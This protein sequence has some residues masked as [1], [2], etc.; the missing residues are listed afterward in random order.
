MTNRVEDN[1]E[2]LHVSNCIITGEDVAE[3]LGSEIPNF[4][5]LGLN[6]SEIYRVYRPKAELEKAY[7]TL[8][9]VP[10]FGKHVWGIPEALRQDLIIGT[11][12]GDAAMSNAQILNTVVFWQAEAKDD[13]D[14]GKKY[15]SAG[16]DYTPVVEDGDWNGNKY[17]VRMTN[18]SFNHV[19]LVDNP[20][21]KQAG[22]A[23]SADNLIKQKQGVIFMKLQ[24]FLKK[25]NVGAMDSASRLVL[26]KKSLDKKS[27]AKF[28]RIA[29]A[30]DEE[31]QDEDP[32]AEDEDDEAQKANDESGAEDDG[33][34]DDE[35]V[36]E[37]EE[38]D[39]AEDEAKDEDDGAKDEEEPAPKGMDSATQLYIQKQINQGISKGIAS[40]KNSI[41]HE[42]GAMD[43]AVNLCTKLVGNVNRG[44]FDSADALYSNVLKQKGVSYLGKTTAQKMAKVEALVETNSLKIKQSGA[45]DKA[46]DSSGLSP[47]YKRLLGVN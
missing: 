12:G 44:A 6:P 4:K 45:M 3:Y 39:K 28:Q 20:R 29:K 42:H 31:V 47:E 25:H 1:N 40:I 26:A 5:E 35:S 22:V 18:I 8:N 10:F 34:E 24:E 11:I 23:D 36:A 9:N 43:E 46:I 33:V 7:T 32:V 16:Y 2:Y 19:A 15:L 21:Y 30:M 37:D 13:L 27:L 41:K 17:D 38:S 14:K